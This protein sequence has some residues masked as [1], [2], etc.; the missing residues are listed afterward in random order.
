M[1]LRHKKATAVLACLCILFTMAGCG[2]GKE[3]VLTTGLGKNDVFQI[4]EAVCTL[5]EAKY[6]LMQMQQGYDQ[7]YGKELWKQTVNGNTIEEYAKDRVIDRLVEVKCMN[8]LAKDRQIELTEEE[9]KT[10]SDTADQQYAALDEETI[11]SLGVDQ[12]SLR[13]FYQ[14]FELA[15]KVYQELTKDVN[16]EVS[17]DEA[18]AVLVQQIF[19]KSESEA[20][21]VVQKAQAGEDFAALAESYN[22]SDEMQKA[23]G[24]GEV[25]SK[26][27]EAVFAL[28]NDEISDVVAT[29]DGYYILKCMNNYDVDATDANKVVIANQRKED[30]FRK[31]YDP[32]VAGLDSEFNQELWDSV[33]NAQ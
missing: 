20:N 22:E 33:G 32:F 16:T 3:I 29:D 24:R 4:G 10:A 11:K 25:D 5:P 6:L 28:A 17:D 27:E 1:K 15:D 2:K 12:E 7:V 21:E 19:T 31:V 9:K 14:E 30:A 26:L 18:R 13:S 23:Y 8:L